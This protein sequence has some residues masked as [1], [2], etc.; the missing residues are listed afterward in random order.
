MSESRPRDKQK[1]KISIK[2][3]KLEENE[4]DDSR[5]IDSR[6]IEDS[7]IDDSTPKK[8]TDIDEK[9]SLKKVKSK[10]IIKLTDNISKFLFGWIESNFLEKSI[11]NTE[12][13]RLKNNLSIVISKTL[14][15]PK[16]D[17][18][19]PKKPMATF[20]RFRKFNLKRIKE[21]SGLE[22]KELSDLVLKT[23]KKLPLTEKGKEEILKYKAEF[24]E[25]TKIYKKLISDYNKENGLVK[26]VKLRR[27]NG[28]N[29]FRKMYKD[30]KIGISA[31]AGIEWGNMLM[32]SDD[33]DK[34]CQLYWIQMA[35]KENI[36][37][38]LVPVE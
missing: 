18:N 32:G 20:F 21:S 25:E 23:W 35:K 34:K 24:K 37:N 1:V 22:G 3:R 30:E 12:K 11:S 26:E 14:I 16:K 8:R 4:S 29:L 17:E 15:K 10:K 9:K 13:T 5:V 36:K 27:T 19:K 38:G 7:D 6:V 33:T 2:S 31:E 28:L